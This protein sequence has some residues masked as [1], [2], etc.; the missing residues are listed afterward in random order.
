MFG[1]YFRTTAEFKHL[2][3][4]ILRM[5]RRRGKDRQLYKRQIEDHFL[6]VWLDAQTNNRAQLKELMK[7][8]KELRK[9]LI[10]MAEAH[11]QEL[12]DLERQIEKLKTKSS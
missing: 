6:K 10:E 1:G 12:D 4:L 3:D 9:T 7:D 8:K 2:E 5:L 11:K